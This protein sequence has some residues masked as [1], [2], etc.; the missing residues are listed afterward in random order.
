MR[1]RLGG[2]CMGVHMHVCFLGMGIFEYGCPAC[3]PPP[4]FPSNE[5]SRPSQSI[6]AHIICPS[7]WPSVGCSFRTRTTATRRG[8]L[9]AQGTTPQVSKR[10]YTDRW[11]TVCAHARSR[12]LVRFITSVPFMHVHSFGQAR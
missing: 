5:L 7:R 10:R 11:V 6:R 9:C 8:P 2:E 4:L 3:P 1:E 12:I